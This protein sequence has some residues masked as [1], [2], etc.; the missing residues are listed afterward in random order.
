MDESIG[1]ARM[2][3]AA[4]RDD[5]ETLRQGAWYPVLSEGSTRLVLD[6]SGRRVAVPQDI[7]EVRP[8]RPDRFTVVYRT[9]DDPNPARGTKADVGRVFAVCPSCASRNRLPRR[10]RLGTSGT[11]AADSAERA[12]CSKCGHEG[13]VA[14]WE[15]G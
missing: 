1:W 11:Y 4:K 12:R 7:V 3:A 10:P 5:A 9:P 13:I 2:W 8:R 14:W 15:T 6:V